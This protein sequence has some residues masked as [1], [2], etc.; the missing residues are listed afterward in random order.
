MIIWLSLLIAILGGLIYYFTGPAP[1]P[2]AGPAPASRW[3]E[4]KELGRIAFAM[5]LLAFLLQAGPYF[6]SIAAHLSR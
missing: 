2:P 5:G 6:L 1:A 4:R 3:Q